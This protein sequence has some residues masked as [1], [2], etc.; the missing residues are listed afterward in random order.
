MC[1]PFFAPSFCV[2]FFRAGEQRTAQENALAKVHPGKAR[3]VGM[4][5]F[6]ETPGGG[7]RLKKHIAFLSVFVDGKEKMEY[8]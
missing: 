3:E 8:N 4:N 1:P 6:V 5:I 7:G 2:C